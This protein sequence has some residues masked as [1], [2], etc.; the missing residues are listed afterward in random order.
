[1]NAIISICTRQDNQ[2]FEEIC[3]KCPDCAYLNAHLSE[4]QPPTK[5]YKE[6][7]ERNKFLLTNLETL[8]E[9]PKYKAVW[10]LKL[11]VYYNIFL[12]SA[13]LLWNE[14]SDMIYAFVVNR[15]EITL[16]TE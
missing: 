11:F 4:G 5:M 12:K 1:M 2:G 6:I 3:Q 16:V 7:N 13:E 14:L 15:P 10:P 8:R 9:V